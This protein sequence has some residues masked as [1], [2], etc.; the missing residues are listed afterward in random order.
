MDSYKKHRG[1]KPLLSQCE[2]HEN[3]WTH[4]VTIITSLNDEKNNKKQYPLFSLYKFLYL[5]LV[6]ALSCPRIHMSFLVFTA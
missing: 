2:S 6:W 1:E 3:S 4:V 5:L